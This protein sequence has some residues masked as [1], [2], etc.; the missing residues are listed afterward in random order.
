MLYEM[1]I[2]FTCVYIKKTWF[3]KL[4]DRYKCRR[5]LPHS[6]NKAAAAAT[7]TATAT[8]AARAPATV[9]ESVKTAEVVKKQ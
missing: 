4:A 8:A 7:A 9:T 2:P 5:D 3:W 1:S 6:T